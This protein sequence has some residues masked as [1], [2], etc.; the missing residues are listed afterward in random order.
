[1]VVGKL[2]LIV[3]N[4]LA[5]NIDVVIIRAYSMGLMMSQIRKNIGLFL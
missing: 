5:K 3:A 1:M 4:I 2:C